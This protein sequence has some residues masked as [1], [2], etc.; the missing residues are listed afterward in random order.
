MNNIKKLLN[1]QNSCVGNIFIRGSEYDR[2]SSDAAKAQ[3]RLE[4]A[5]DTE[6]KKLLQKF[7]DAQDDLHRLNIEEYFCGGFR[8]GVRLTVEGL[9][10]KSDNFYE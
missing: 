2:L 5:L 6:Q 7:C 3:S 4:S 9:F 8:T 1:D 10:G